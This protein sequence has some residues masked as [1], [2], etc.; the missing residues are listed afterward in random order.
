[1][2]AP[3][4]PTP[5]GESV[6]EKLRRLWVKIDALPEK[7]RPHLRALAEAIAEQHRRLQGQ[8]SATPPAP[9]ASTA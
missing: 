6:E 1:M 3:Q 7:Q 5:S 8:Q 4:V 9:D 2:N